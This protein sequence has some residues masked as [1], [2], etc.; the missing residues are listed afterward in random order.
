M[1]VVNVFIIVKQEEFYLIS[2]TTVLG[3]GGCLCEWCKADTLCTAKLN[4]PTVPGY[5]DRRE[6]SLG[7]GGGE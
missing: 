4:G 7:G 1:S 5:V 6:G 3:N 2:A